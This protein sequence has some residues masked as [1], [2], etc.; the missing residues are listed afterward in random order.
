MDRSI[1]C[2][3]VAFL[4][5]AFAAYLMVLDRRRA[6]YLR[7]KAQKMYASPLYSA[8]RPVLRQAQ[9]SPLESLTVEQAGL[10]FHFLSPNGYALRFD[11]AAHGFP[12]L[13]M[14][15]QEALLLILEENIPKLAARNHYCFRSI[16][17]KLLNG[18]VEYRYKF[19]IRIDYK[20][21]LTLAPYYDGSLQSQ[22]W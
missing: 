14:E 1:A 3:A 19:I 4:G 13:S 2:L 17:K 18:Q 8:L 12:P 22:L 20:N 16:R 5:V 11:M 21:K 9:K 15:K 10:A 6:R 7:L